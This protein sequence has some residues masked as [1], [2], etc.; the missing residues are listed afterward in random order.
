MRKTKV[1]TTVIFIVSFFIT[2]TSIAATK[3]DVEWLTDITLTVPAN[4]DYIRYLGLKGEPG[5][6]FKLGDIDADILV[7]ELFSMY[8]P[9]CQKAAPTVN[10][11]YKKMEQ[12]TRPDLKL[13]I[14]GIGASNT[15]LEVDT[16]RQGFDIAF[17]LFPDPDLHIYHAL[18][19]TGTPTFIGI[20]KDGDRSVIF[21]RQTGRFRDHS[22]FLDNLLNRSGLKAKEVKHDR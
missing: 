2:I 15:S 7:I 14:I 6:E 11:L 13:V 16:F 18:K 3:S 10:E 9:H 20:K 12:M 1:L 17:P 5:T 21:S 19:G 4:K 22:E 8:C